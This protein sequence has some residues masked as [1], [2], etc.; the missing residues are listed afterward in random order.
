MGVGDVKVG[1]LGVGNV[2]TKNDEFKE[3]GETGVAGADQLSGDI[4]EWSTISPVDVVSGVI[5]GV[6]DQTRVGVAI[7]TACG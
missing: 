4:D 3:D 5:G 2:G 7:G 1:D 6:T